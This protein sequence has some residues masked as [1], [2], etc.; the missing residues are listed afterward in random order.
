MFNFLTYKSCHEHN[1]KGTIY[2][3]MWKLHSS[4]LSYS[5]I[6]FP[7]EN[8]SSSLNIVVRQSAWLL[9]YSYRSKFPKIKSIL[10]D[11][12]QAALT[13]WCLLSP[14]FLALCRSLVRC[15]WLHLGE[16]LALLL[17]LPSAATCSVLH[18]THP[19]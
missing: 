8:V 16:V 7:S 17:C 11:I 5:F 13:E 6:L 4:P 3:S 15:V 2:Q 14:F 19:K 10:Q 9:S 18:I 1:T 12:M